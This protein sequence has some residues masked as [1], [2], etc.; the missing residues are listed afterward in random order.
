MYNLQHIEF[1]FDNLELP[2]FKF[3]AV[4]ALI[5]SK[6]D[7][8]LLDLI[9]SDEYNSSVVNSLDEFNDVLLVVVLSS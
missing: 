2:R 3:C 7:T 8:Q 9:K 5:L 6:F 4:A 1:K